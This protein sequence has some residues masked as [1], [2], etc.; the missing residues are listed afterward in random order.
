M[1]SSALADVANWNE[2]IDLTQY[3]SLDLLLDKCVHSGIC[4]TNLKL[5][6]NFSMAYM[7]SVASKSDSDLFWSV[8]D[9]NAGLS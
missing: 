5:G 2:A 6:Q 4:V 1:H 8:E 7:P 3:L 9:P